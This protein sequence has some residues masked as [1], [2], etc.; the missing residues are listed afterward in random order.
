[1]PDHSQALTALEQANMTRYRRTADRR[2]IRKLDNRHGK[3]ATAQLLLDV[4]DEWRTANLLEVLMVPRYTRPP[5]VE[6]LV[7]GV[8][9]LPLTATVE[10]AGPVKRAMLAGALRADALQP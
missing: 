3:L 10:E 9:G 8:A 5:T 6:R 4:P 2:R 1:M 7:A